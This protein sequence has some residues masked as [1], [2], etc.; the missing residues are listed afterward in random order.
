MACS[1]YR[2]ARFDYRN[3]GEHSKFDPCTTLKLTPLPVRNRR[4]RPLRSRGAIQPRVTCRLK[5]SSTQATT[6][7]ESI[8][9]EVKAVDVETR[10]VEPVEA[11]EVYLGHVFLVWILHT[12]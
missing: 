4:L 10:G 11:S 6:A 1:A 9:D 12:R 8:T 7:S 5:F 2:M 3:S